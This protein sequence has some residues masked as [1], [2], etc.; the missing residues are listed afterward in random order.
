M[1]A[2]FCGC[3]CGEITNIST[4]NSSKGLVKGEPYRFIRGH[5][6]RGRKPGNWKG[7]KTLTYNGYILVREAGRTEYEHRL[8]AGKVLGRKLPELVV[9]HHHGGKRSHNNG[10]LVICQDA[11]YHHLLHVQTQAFLSCGN[12]FYRKCTYCKKYGD[13][14]DMKSRHSH[15]RKNG[16]KTYFHATC[17]NAY[18]REYKKLRRNTHEH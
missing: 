7:G 15:C 5:C 11:A 16:E 9:V 3:G 17:R 4:Q 1:A 13:P 6:N 2:I 8:I 10:N 12:A 14:N 18:A